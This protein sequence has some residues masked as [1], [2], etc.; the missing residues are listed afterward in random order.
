M[1]KR[2]KGT[3]S[4]SEFD[5]SDY[6]QPFDLKIDVQVPMSDGVSLSTDVYLP[7]TG[8]PFPAL[9]VRT[10]YDNQSPQL[11]EAAERFVASGYAVVMQDC[12]GRFDSDGEWQPYVNEAQDG[13]DTQEWIGSQPWC[14]GSIGTFGTSY[15]GFTQSL[16]APMRSKY[17][18]ALV[19]TVSQQDNFGH[20]YVDG[21]LQLHVAM[22][23]INMAGRTMQRGSRNAMNSAEFYRRL[24]LISALDDIVDL[25]FYREV[26]TH[27][28]FD[29]FWKSYSMRYRYEDV[30]TPALIVSGWYDNLVH[31]AF[32]L[33][34]GW[35]TGSRSSETRRLTKLLIG[36]WSHGNIGSSEPFG[37]IGFGP[38]AG[39][40]FIEEQLRWYDR[41][42]KGIDNGMDDEPPIRIFVMGDNEFRFE[43]EW[44]L[45]RTRYTNYYLH[46]RGGAN[47][48]HGNGAL[49][50]EMPGDE[51][52]DRYSYDPNDPVPTL[53]GQI[54][55]IQMTVSGPWDRRPVER[56]DDVLVYTTEPLAEDVE[57]TGPVFL[58]LCVQS[59]APDTDFTGTLVDVH[60]DGKA[61]IICEGLLRCRYRDSIEDPALMTPGE[62]YELTVDMWETSNV[63]EAGHSIRLEVS[64]SN[65]PRFDRNLNTGGQPGMDAEMNTAEQT[66]FH[67]AERPSYLTLPIIPR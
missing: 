27:S 39:M 48:L 28:T 55:A 29:D 59:S 56:R 64:S 47:S 49:S 1:Y 12:R 3:S 67:D 23:F 10:I 54:M 46:S 4:M 25:P 45:A 24:P 42:L 32:K 62:T 33:Y 11:I 26:I 9:L 50:T 8:G 53:G 21:A 31:E 44:P 18:K 13:H 2:G 22:N 6:S 20:F 30:E 51:P 65:F 58:N 57:V 41:R 7:K 36:G 52:P 16:T 38:A 40:D 5:G 19:P 35:T 66:I 37:T 34:K 43:N 60:P 15:V 14:D 63:F 17:L 61:I